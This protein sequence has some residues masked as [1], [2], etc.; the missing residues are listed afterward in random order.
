MEK[1]E[2]NDF[3]KDNGNKLYGELYIKNTNI[4]ID[5]KNNIIYINIHNFISIIKK[6]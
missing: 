2:L 4:K 3:Q 1:F 6:I 5:G